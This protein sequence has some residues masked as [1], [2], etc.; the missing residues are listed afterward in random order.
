MCELE[1]TLIPKLQDIVSNWP[2]CVDNAFAT[3][4]PKNIEMVKKE[5]N[6]L[7]KTIRKYEKFAHELKQG[8]K[9][10]FS[11]VLIKKRTKLK[12]AF[13]ESQRILTYT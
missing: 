3:I 9:I 2:R 5:L 13:K 11:D 7:H 6:S 1:N 4:E 10:P 12:V 8:R